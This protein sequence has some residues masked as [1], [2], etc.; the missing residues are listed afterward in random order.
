MKVYETEQVP[1]FVRLYSTYDEMKMISRYKND[2]LQDGI[3]R[4]IFSNG[5]S[6]YGT[7]IFSKSL[8]NGEENRIYH[9]Y[10]YADGNIEYVEKIW[11]EGLDED[12]RILT[13]YRFTPNNLG[14]EKVDL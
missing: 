13:H 11:I 1:G 7:Q 14:W 4:E 12:W 2:K 9:L 5:D 6:D 10:K 3:Y 8:N